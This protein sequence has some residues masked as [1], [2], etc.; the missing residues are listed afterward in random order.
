MN[1]A[2]STDYLQSIVEIHMLETV[3]CSGLPISG[4]DIGELEKVQRQTMRLYGKA[5]IKGMTK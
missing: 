4:G 3:C 5:Y 1:Q 2:E